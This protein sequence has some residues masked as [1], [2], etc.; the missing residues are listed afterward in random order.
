MRGITN[1]FSVIFKN[2]QA[3]IGFV[4][5]LVFLL[6]ATIG[7][8]FVP[9]MKTNYAERLKLPS[10]EHLLGTD[11]SGRDTLSQF[12]TGSR[13][14]LLVA[15]LAALFSMTIAIVVGMVSGVVG[16]KVDS[17]LM[18]VTNVV[19]TV[20]SFPI[21]MVLSMLIKISNPLLF[22]LVLS[23]WSWAGLARAI[24]SQILSLKNRDFVEAS[25]ILGLGL[26]HTIFAEILPNVTSYIAINF[27]II[28]RGAITASVGLMVL[29][30]VPFS[31]SHWGM[32]LQL[33]TSSTGA[34]YG[35]SAIFYF[36]VP[37]SGIVLFQMG[38]LFFATGLDE[39]LNPRLRVQ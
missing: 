18:M 26:R 33:A 19:L 37:V 16:G 1:F 31:A 12:V 10:F 25:R 22:G 13:T 6:M 9:P 39:A 28:M 35:S 17:I 2:R 24:R 38:C 30:L 14:V 15:F 20:P 36:F 34:L 29:G 4:I 32:M 3:T 27:I 23:I 5:L 7:P 11:Y 21:M 8:F